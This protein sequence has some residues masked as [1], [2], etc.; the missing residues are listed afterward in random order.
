MA[1]EQR[2]LAA[3]VAADV[4]G[5]S[6]LM[7]HDESGTLAALKALRGDIVDPA[8]GEHGGRI[9]KTTGDGLLLEFPSVVDSVRCAISIQQANLARNADVPEDLQLILRIGVN[10]GD[11]LVEGDDIFGD[12]VNIAARLEQIAEPG[13]ICLSQSAH[14]G[15]RQRI[16]TRF[17]DGGERELKNIA[18]KVR[19]WHWP[20]VPAA[21]AAVP[22]PD[23]PSIAVL[24]FENMSGDPEQ[25]YFADGVVDDIITALARFPSLFVIARNSSFTYRG[26]AIDIRRVGLELGV[27]YVLEGGVRRTGA[28]LRINAQLIDVESRSHLWAERYDGAMDDLFELQ[29]RIASSIAGALVP[30]LERAEIERARRKPPERLDAYDLYLQALALAFYDSREDNDR[31]L[32]L[33][34]KSLALAPGF[35]PALLLATSAWGARRQAGWVTPEEGLAKARAFF[36]RARQIDKDNPEM[37]AMSA[38]GMTMFSRLAAEALATVETA[39]ALNPNSATCWTSSGWV[40]VYAG[41]LDTAVEHFRRA[42]RLSPRDPRAFDVWSGLSFAY[43]QLGRDEDA[44]LAARAS[45][46]QSAKYAPARRFLASALALVGRLEEARENVRQILADEP[47]FSVA[48]LM[49]RVGMGEGEASRY[50]QG[51]RTAGVPEAATG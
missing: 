38:R 31:A 11:V 20:D 9:V 6:R 24:P 21:Q 42:Q 39:V 17:V 15:V 33:L 46:Q 7:G 3:I 12:G 32:V 8:I 41:R 30:S 19:I 44:I 29:D 14:E 18:E 49:S 28:K 25:A 1:R 50:L 22:L 23:K 4:V 47:D 51:L 45:L 10:L 2:R 40:N 13:G 27:R 5:Y 35:M 43:I 37:L 36:L 16:G 48:K 34:E 26:S